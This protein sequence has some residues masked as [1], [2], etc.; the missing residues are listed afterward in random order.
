MSPEHKGGP[1]QDKPKPD[2]TEQPAIVEQEEDEPSFSEQFAELAKRA[3]TVCDANVSDQAK[4]IAR[5]LQRQ[6]ELLTK[7]TQKIEVWDSSQTV[8]EEAVAEELVERLY[9]PAP[10]VT[11]LWRVPQFSE[12][13]LL[14]DIITDDNNSRFEFSQWLKDQYGIEPIFPN[15]EIDSFN[16]VFHR[17][18][19]GSPL[20]TPD[21]SRDQ[22]ILNVLRPG[23][24]EN[25]KGISQAIVWRA[26]Y[27]TKELENDEPVARAE[28]LEEQGP[29]GQE[30]SAQPEKVTAESLSQHIH[31]TVENLRGE[32]ER[33]SKKVKVLIEGLLYKYREFSTLI[34]SITKND[35]LDDIKNN[36][37]ATFDLPR[38]TDPVKI[39]MGTIDPQELAAVFKYLSELNA[40]ANSLKAWLVKEHKIELL[41]P[42]EGD[43][44]DPK[45]HEDNP[46]HRLPTH[47]DKDHNRIYA[48]LR[49]GVKQNGKVFANAFVKRFVLVVDTPKTEPKTDEGV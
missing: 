18:G 30:Q 49:A 33:A 14:Q 2:K 38:I 10:V 22:L 40:I 7:T 48:I 45:I 8:K 26:L 24:V 21:K 19:A 6:L 36:T 47:T 15:V 12:E 16:S 29:V 41:V 23:V 4:S 5:R 17:D 34:E 44:F 20:I 43:M 37:L 39:P 32:A 11:E 42:I 25:V 13:S 1:P 28:Y 27:D 46:L 9:G 3:E 35:D 31:D